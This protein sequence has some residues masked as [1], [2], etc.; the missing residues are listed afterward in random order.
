MSC[1]P[2]KTGDSIVSN[3]PGCTSF[4]LTVVPGAKRRCRCA[5]ALSRQFPDAFPSLHLDP[6]RRHLEREILHIDGTHTK[7]YYM[8]ASRG[9]RQHEK[10]LQGKAEIVQDA[11][12][13]PDFLHPSQQ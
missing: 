12:D 4:P 9:T 2:W 10:I 5:I 7:I 3:N 13:A 1:I 11:E 6:Q 8:R